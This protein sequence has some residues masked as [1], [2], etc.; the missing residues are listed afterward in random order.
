MRI[1]AT[2]YTKHTHT[3]T[4]YTRNAN[5]HTDAMT[6][7]CPRRIRDT[8]T[9]YTQH[10]LD[11]EFHFFICPKAPPSHKTAATHESIFTKLHGIAGCPTYLTLDAVDVR[12]VG[13]TP[14]TTVL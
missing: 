8:D 14:I 12:D 10:T 2:I 6:A 9:L 7:Q 13:K 11:S 5:T 3:N 1:L 4:I